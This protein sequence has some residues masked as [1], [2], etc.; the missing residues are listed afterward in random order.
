MSEAIAFDARRSVKRRAGPGF[1]ERQAKEHV[2]LLNG[3]LAARTGL[4]RVRAEVAKVEA[5]VEEAKSAILKRVFGALVARG[6]PI[7][8]SV[9][10]P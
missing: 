4:E 1:A 3:N 10:L 2:V 8:A 7:V 9:K 5:R 6:G